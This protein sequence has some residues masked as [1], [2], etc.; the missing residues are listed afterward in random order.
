L[1]ASTGSPAYDVDVPA[2]RLALRMAVTGARMLGW[3]DAPLPD[4]E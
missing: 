2:D 1:A 4:G 3:P